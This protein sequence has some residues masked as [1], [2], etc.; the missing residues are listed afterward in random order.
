[1]GYGGIYQQIKEQAARIVKAGQSGTKRALQEIQDVIIW[2]KLIRVNDVPP[3]KNIQGIIRVRLN[4]AAHYAVKSAKY[5][6]SRARS[7]YNDIKIT[8]KRIR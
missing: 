6:S 1:M 3:A 7:T 2:T 5:V 4:T 8:I